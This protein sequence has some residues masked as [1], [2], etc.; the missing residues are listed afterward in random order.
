MFP[1]LNE[2]L[3]LETCLGS[4]HSLSV[5]QDS[6]CP[7]KQA[8]LTP[9]SFSRD[10]LDLL[11]PKLATVIK[12]LSD[13]ARIYREQACLGYTHGQPAA[14]TTVLV[15]FSNPRF[16]ISLYRG[17]ETFSGPPRKRLLTLEL[18]VKRSTDS[19]IIQRE[20]SMSLDS[21]SSNGF[22]E[23]GA[24]SIRR[25]LSRCEGVQFSF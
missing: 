20:E 13:F 23:Y 25:P 16:P 1:L 4:F 24:L 21:R 10:G 6:L 14:L 12:K 17:L 18:S 7:L 8:R 11:L 22:E 19:E 2:V 15:V 3:S 5:F 9:K